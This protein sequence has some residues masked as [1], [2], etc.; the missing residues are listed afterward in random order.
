MRPPFSKGDEH[1]GAISRCRGKA[2][3]P[4]GER[5]AFLIRSVK[6]AFEFTFDKSNKTSAR[7]GTD[8]I[9]KDGMYIKR[10]I[11]VMLG[12]GSINH[13]SRRFKAENIDA[14]R[15]QFNKSFYDQP[16]KQVYHNL[17]DEALERYNSK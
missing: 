13:N 5:K 4:L 2:P 1:W 8:W 15:T 12:K 11:S 10:T 7:A 14:D 3:H 6:N 16:I 9:G 17:F